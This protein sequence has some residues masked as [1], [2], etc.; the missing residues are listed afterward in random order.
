MKCFTIEKDYTRQSIIK[1]LLTT[2]IVLINVRK[3]ESVFLR[4]DQYWDRT[5]FFMIAKTLEK[6]KFIWPKL[7]DQRSLEISSEQLKCK[8][9]RDFGN[10]LKNN[11]SYYK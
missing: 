10:T 3:S 11:L 5:G 2:K 1:H 6:D 8:S 9:S 7:K 4:Q